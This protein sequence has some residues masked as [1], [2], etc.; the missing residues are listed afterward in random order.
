MLSSP[1]SR[2]SPLPSSPKGKLK[3]HTRPAVDGK[4]ESEEAMQQNMK[5]GPHA[6]AHKVA[7]RRRVAAA[8]RER[9]RIP[10]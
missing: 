10:A 7:V 2:P 5:P 8:A 9:E 3:P 6:E 1:T 4:K